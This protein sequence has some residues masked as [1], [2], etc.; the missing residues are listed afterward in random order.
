MIWKKDGNF[1]KAWSTISKIFGAKQSESEIQQDESVNKD[2][3]KAMAVSL[4]CGL[5][6]AIG[7]T[8]LYIAFSD[9]AVNNLNISVCTAILSGN[10]IFALIA[11]LTIFKDKITLF[12]TLGVFINLGGVLIISLSQGSGGATPTMVIGSIIS[13]F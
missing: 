3:I 1:M 9:A 7:M 11:S 4:I 8:S 13:S 5:F 10:C 6:N 12:Q 2:I